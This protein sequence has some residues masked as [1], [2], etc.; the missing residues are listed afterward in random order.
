MTKRKTGRPDII[1]VFRGEDGQWYVTRKSINGQPRLTSEG[2]TRKSAAIAC[3]MNE[4]N[5]A[6]VV[7]ED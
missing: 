6:R 3:A 4:G 1:R 5:L 7:I 2:Y